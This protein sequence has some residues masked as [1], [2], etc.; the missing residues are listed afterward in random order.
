MKTVDQSGKPIVLKR[1]I[2]HLFPLEVNEE[3]NEVQKKAIQR[4]MRI[5]RTF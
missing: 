3:S 4:R 2:V 1:S 5:L